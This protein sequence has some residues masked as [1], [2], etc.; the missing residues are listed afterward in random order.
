MTTIAYHHG[1]QTIAYDSRVTAGSQI[2]TDNED[3]K[4]EKDGRVFFLAGNSGDIDR[5][6]FS[7]PDQVELSDNPYGFMVEK[8]IV[9]W[10]SYEDGF[11][12]TTKLKHSQSAGSGGDYALAA[13]DCG[14][15]AV[16]AVKVAIGR[17]VYSGGKVNV[18]KVDEC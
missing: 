5:A 12:I 14:C 2:F 11:P 10:V 8:G 9:Y 17:D 16:E 13:M 4:R 15:G 6:V 18:F 1:T 7:F 3:K